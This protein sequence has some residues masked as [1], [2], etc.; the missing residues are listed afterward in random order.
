MVYVETTAAAN[1]DKVTQCLAI[2]AWTP[3]ELAAMQSAYNIA[4]KRI[5]FNSFC[6]AQCFEA[7]RHI[8]E[9]LLRELAGASQLLG[10]TGVMDLIQGSDWQA[11]R[12]DGMVAVVHELLSRSSA[13]FEND[14]W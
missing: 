13:I 3:E 5:P 2:A 1:H 14:G 4:V 10:G 12:P 11:A 7:V 6:Q 9:A 8:F